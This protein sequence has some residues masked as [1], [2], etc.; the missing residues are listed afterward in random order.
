MRGSRGGGG[1]GSDPSEKSP[2][3]I[4]FFSNTGQ[5]PLKITNIPSQHS[6]LGH[7][8]YAS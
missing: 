1:R 3:N 6:M 8:W 2:K 5:D 4:V 7:H